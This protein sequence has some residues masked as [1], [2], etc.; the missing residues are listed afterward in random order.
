MWCEECGREF[1]EEEVKADLIRFYNCEDGSF[2]CELC[3]ESYME[4]YY[5]GMVS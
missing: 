4:R 5:E 2:L 3:Y 1:I